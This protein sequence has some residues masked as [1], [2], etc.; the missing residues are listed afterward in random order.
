MDKEIEADVSPSGNAAIHR[1]THAFRVAVAG[2]VELVFTIG[3]A[4]EL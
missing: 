1:L 2:A 4:V 3:A